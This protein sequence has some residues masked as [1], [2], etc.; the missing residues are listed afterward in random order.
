M[1]SVIP[2]APHELGGETAIRGRRRDAIGRRLIGTRIRCGDQID[3]AW[4]LEDPGT[5]TTIIAAMVPG[6]IVVGLA[7]A[8]RPGDGYRTTVPRAA[9]GRPGDGYRTNVT[10]NYSADDRWAGS[11]RNP[12]SVTAVRVTK[13]SSSALHVAAIHTH[14]QTSLACIG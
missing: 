8:G 10:A 7:A 1:A 4:I 5:S 2:D 6:Y 12:S 14:S 13:R 3:A 9:S 11:L